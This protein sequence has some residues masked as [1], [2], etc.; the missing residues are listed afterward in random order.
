[1]YIAEKKHDRHNGA[2]G[3]KMSFRVVGHCFEFSG[4]LRMTFEGSI[5]VNT[6]F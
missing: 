5:R 1:M 4:N 2:I 6:Y 3:K